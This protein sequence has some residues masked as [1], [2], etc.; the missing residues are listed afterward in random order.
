[1]TD[2][3]RQPESDGQIVDRKLR[4]ILAAVTRATSISAM[5]QIVSLGFD[6]KTAWTLVMEALR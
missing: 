6:R 2:P 1:M 5:R 4:A 3:T